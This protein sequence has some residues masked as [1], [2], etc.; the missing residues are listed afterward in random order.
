MDFRLSITRNGKWNDAS[1][2]PEYGMFRCAD[3]PGT[4]TVAGSGYGTTTDGVGHGRHSFFQPAGVLTMLTRS[5]PRRSP[6]VP[7][8]RTVETLVHTAVADRFK[9]TAYVNNQNWDISDMAQCRSGSMCPVS[10]TF[11]DQQFEVP[12]GCASMNMDVTLNG[13]RGNSHKG[14]ALAGQQFQW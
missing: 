10:K 6:L 11:T 13:G 1:S 5:F 3:G 9:G 4:A 14:G 12:M 7:V 2:A 8:R